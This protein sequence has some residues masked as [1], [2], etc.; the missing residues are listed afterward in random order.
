MKGTADSN[1]HILPGA[2]S[3]EW[4]RSLPSLARP[5]L[6]LLCLLLIASIGLPVP[7][8]TNAAKPDPAKANM[9]AQDYSRFSHSSPR[10]HAD[11]MGRENCGS[12]HRRTDGTLAP[13]FPLHKDC[14]GC[15]LVQFTASNSSSPV[16]PICTICHRGE[17]LNSSNPPL[18]NFPRLLSFTAAFDHAQHLQG[19]ESARPGK[20]CAACHTPAN[21]GLAETIP[22]RLNAHQICYE[23]HSPGKQASKSSSC[24]SCHTLGRYS[25]TSTSARAYRM[26][27]S[28]ADHGLRQRLTCDRCHNVR[29]RGLPQARQVTSIVAVQHLSNS[30]TQ[31]C[32]TCHNGQ[33]AFGESANFADCSRC[34]KGQG[35]RMGE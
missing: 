7:A 19:I 13:R 17:G 30:R 31:S 26:G 5:L 14:T 32:I 8:V 6:V 18:K 15:H 21:R 25:Q 27:F 9:P 16:N 22:A 35:F 12:C 24:G 4:M 28:H 34:H 29:G 10:E 23:C 3:G 2:S 20:S 1:S 33:R 11:L